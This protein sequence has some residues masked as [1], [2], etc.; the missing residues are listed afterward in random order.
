LQLQ[1]D[2][3]SCYG[4]TVE[5]GT[6]FEELQSRGALKLPD[7]EAFPELYLTVH[8]QLTSAGFEHYEISN[9]AQPGYHCRHN[10]AYWRR[11]TC[12]AVGA[13]AHSFDAAGYGLR[14]A[15]PADL[16][17]YRQRLN[18][19]HD[20]AETLEIFDRQGAMA[21]TLYLGL[22]CSEGVADK[23][24]NHRFGLGIAEAFPD[25]IRRCGEHLNLDGGRWRFD[26]QGWLLYD[27]FIS[28][29]L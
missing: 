1:P 29:F 23:D 6:P 16:Q 2:H 10:L 21:E 7:E 17:Y 22:R 28:F 3:Q 8:E 12:F 26:L 24:F 15:V 25:A 11:Q 20:P 4:L 5:A 18:Q 14:R 19:G 9:Y 13:G 27:Y